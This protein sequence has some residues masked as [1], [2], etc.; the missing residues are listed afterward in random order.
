MKI[1]Q[2]PMATLLVVSFSLPP[3]LLSQ[4]GYPA[5]AVGRIAKRTVQGSGDTRTSP[6]PAVT[7]TGEIVRTT[8]RIG[9]ELRADD[10]TVLIV[11]T[12]S[13]FPVGACV[14]VSGYAD[15]PSRTHFSFGR[16]TLAAS[17]Q[18]Q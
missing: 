11:Q 6:I 13:D 15:G 17:D 8:A 16:A 5:T 18:C 9:Y 1:V 7:K 10:G 3:A 14:A 2:I 12:T 4:T